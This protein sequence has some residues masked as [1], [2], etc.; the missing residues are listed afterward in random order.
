MLILP[1]QH[2]RASTCYSKP[3]ITKLIIYFTKKTYFESRMK[4]DF[5][6]PLESPNMLGVK[7]LQVLHNSG[8]SILLD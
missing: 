7:R 2:R 3:D 1:K 4:D 8:A 5:S 6:M